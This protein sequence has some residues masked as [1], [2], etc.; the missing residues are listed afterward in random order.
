MD[1]IFTDDDDMKTWRWQFALLGLGLGLTGAGC[2]SATIVRLETPEPSQR[3]EL[4]V[5]RESSFNVGGIGMVLA[6]TARIT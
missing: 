4:L 6:P 2:T 5:Y 1:W 3:A